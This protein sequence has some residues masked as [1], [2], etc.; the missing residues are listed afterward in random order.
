MRFAGK[1]YIKE[2]IT[3]TVVLLIGLTLSPRYLVYSDPPRK[4]DIIVQFVGPDQEARLKEAR[5]LVKEGY[6]DYLFIPT[7]FS[8]YRANQDRTGLATIRLTDIKPIDFSG[9]RSLKGNSPAYLRKI[10][11]EYRFPRYYEDTHAEILLA[12]SAM[13]ACGLRSAIFVSS[14]YHMERI[15]MITK[16]VFGEQARYISYVPTHYENDPIDLRD[17]DWEDWVFV[18]QEYIKI[19]WFSLYS[20]FI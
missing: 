10:K 19:C 12:K 3:V 4:S 18:I 7:L 9:S 15:R 8:L 6:S 1:H 11:S 13:D 2:T 17:M 20:P 5:Q 16:R 14:P